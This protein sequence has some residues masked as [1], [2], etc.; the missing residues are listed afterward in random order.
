MTAYLVFSVDT[1]CLSIDFPTVSF[2]LAMDDSMETILL[3]S[4][5]SP[6]WWKW[7]RRHCFG[8]AERM[9][10]EAWREIDRFIAAC[11]AEKRKNSNRTQTSTDLLSSYMNDINDDQQG[12]EIDHKFLQS[13]GGLENTGG[14]EDHIKRTIKLGWADSVRARGTGEDGVPPCLVIGGAEVVPFGSY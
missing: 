4:T 3:H 5:V 2:V 1:S 9:M 12:T 7:I 11:V 13:H 10:V 6:V 14:I 8:S